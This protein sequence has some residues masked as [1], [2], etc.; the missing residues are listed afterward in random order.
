MGIHQGDGNGSNLLTEVHS[1][2]P[3]LVQGSFKLTIRGTQ[4]LNLGL[5]LL[6]RLSHSLEPPFHL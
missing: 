6:V 1:R 4:F 5:Q 3:V 2:F